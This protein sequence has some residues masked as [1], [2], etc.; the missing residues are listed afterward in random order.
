MPAIGR[1]LASVTGVVLPQKTVNPDKA[2]A[3]GYA[4]QVGILDGINT[5]LQVLSPI[6]IEAAMMRALAKKRGM[7]VE[8]DEFEDLDEFSTEEVF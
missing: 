5:E 3:L 2:V 6:A 7:D 8:E 4:V 1:L